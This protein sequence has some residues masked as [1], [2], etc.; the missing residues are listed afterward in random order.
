MEL[1]SFTLKSKS[2]FIMEDLRKFANLSHFFIDN[3][4]IMVSSIAILTNP[5]QIHWLIIYN[6]QLI[7]VA[8]LQPQLC[9]IFFT[10]CLAIYYSK[11]STNWCWPIHTFCWAICSILSTPQL[12]GDGLLQQPIAR[13]KVTNT[14]EIAK[15]IL[16][17]M[18]THGV[19][20]IHNHVKAHWGWIVFGKTRWWITNIIVCR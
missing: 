13:I 4:A 6:R 11:R 1:S 3:N 20:Y 2:I 12:I 14:Y 10:F 15:R 18:L 16:S 17:L 7:N 5:I 9:T 19:E 8:M